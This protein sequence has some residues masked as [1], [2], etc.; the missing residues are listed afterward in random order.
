MSVFSLVCILSGLALLLPVA[1][2]AGPAL[3]IDRAQVSIRGDATVQSARL[4]DMRLGVVVEML[5]R[6]DE[7]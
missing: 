7:W 6:K 3:M 2:A 4:D 5:G 1:A